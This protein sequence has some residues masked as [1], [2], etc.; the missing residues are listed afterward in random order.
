MECSYTDRC[1]TS[2]V[3]GACKCVSIHGETSR[4]WSSLGTGQATR[5]IF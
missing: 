5:I 2:Q 4:D 3:K 1:E